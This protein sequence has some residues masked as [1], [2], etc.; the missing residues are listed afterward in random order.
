MINEVFGLLRDQLNAFL[1]VRSGVHPGD[2]VDSKVDFIESTEG[3]V[4]PANKISMLLVNIE[5]GNALRPPD[6]Y[7]A[8]STDGTR[9]KVQPE[10]RLDLYVLFVAGFTKDTYKEGLRNLSLV[11]QYFQNHR[12]L[13]H[14]NTPGLSESIEQ[15]MLEL[16]TMPLSQQNEIWSALRTAY[17]PSVLYRVKMVVFRDDS[18]TSTPTIVEKESTLRNLL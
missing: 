10:I 16:V 14:Q 15:L 7:A 12:V 8:I 1:Q 2:S 17:H 5:E 4:F 11:I 18:A 13:D 3:T 9:R 6:L